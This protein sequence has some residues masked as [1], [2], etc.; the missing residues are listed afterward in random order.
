M[1]VLHGG[2]TPDEALS[3]G[4]LA[5]R[6]LREP[7]VQTWRQRTLG[8]DAP[9]APALFR[10]TGDSV[11]AWTGRG[12][13]WRLGRLLRPTRAWQVVQLLSGGQ[14]A[15]N[16]VAD[17]GRRRFVKQLGG[18]A[19]AAGLLTLGPR[20]GNAADAAAPAGA[21]L[22][23]DWLSTTGG[24]GKSLVQRA[25][26][27]GEVRQLRAWLAQTGWQ[28]ERISA[29]RA[30][31]NG[32]Q[33]SAAFFMDHAGS[34]VLAYV[35]EAKPCVIRPNADGP[36]AIFIIRHGQVEQVP[37]DQVPANHSVYAALHGGTGTPPAGTVVAADCCTDCRACL[38]G[39]ILC[40]AFAG[41]CFFGAV[42]CCPVG[43][44]VCAA[45]VI[46]C[47]RQI[48]CDCLACI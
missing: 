33:S 10:V 16:T 26:H 7:E 4:R 43:L 15:L 39:N 9:W 8:A 42:F 48:G 29:F 31:A 11:R 24:E 21:A 1:R 2:G 30:R 18:A 32:Q 38:A 41:C 37:Q 47:S 23:V 44:G 40:F 12:L 17:G 14:P 22:Q 6:S 46:Q 35:V 28:S 45:V 20:L 34:A 3:A 13:A 36:D 5:A 19:M 27:D 25:Q